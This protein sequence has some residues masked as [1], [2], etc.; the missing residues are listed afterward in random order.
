MLLAWHS[1]DPALRACEGA[2]ALA[3]RTVVAVSAGELSLASAEGPEALTQQLQ[4]LTAQDGRPRLAWQ[5]V[6]SNP[7]TNLSYIC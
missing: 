4:Q 3:G 2:G 7:G 6:D 1:M 5:S